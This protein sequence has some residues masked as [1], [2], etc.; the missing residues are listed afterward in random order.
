MAT[1]HFDFTSLGGIGADDHGENDSHSSFS[2]G[3]EIARLDGPRNELSRLL[4]ENDWEDALTM[5]LE[6]C[7]ASTNNNTG[8]DSIIHLA[9]IAETRNGKYEDR[10]GMLPLHYACR[11]GAP[12]NLIR[13]LLKAHPEGALAR[14]KES[15]RIALHFVAGG[16]D[17]GCGKRLHHGQ[18]QQ[19]PCREETNNR[20]A[21]ARILLSAFPQSIEMKDH[22][23]GMS[24]LHLACLV[25]AEPDLLAVLVDADQSDGVVS[26]PDDG[27]NLPLH[28]MFHPRISTDSVRRL[29]HAYPNGA[30]A[31]DSNGALPLHKACAVGAPVDAIRLLLSQYPHGAWTA[32]G[33]GNL[34]LHLIVP[35][36]PDGEVKQ[37]VRDA[38]I[39]ARADSLQE[40]LES[41]PEGARARNK[42][43]ETPFHR[44]LSEKASL[45]L[46]QLFLDA[47][48][49]C[50]KDIVSSS[51]T[52]KEGAANI[53]REKPSSED[54]AV[55]NIM[56]SLA[57]TSTTG[58]SPLH[59]ACRYNAPTDVIHALLDI[60]PQQARC[61]ALDGPGGAHLPIHAACRTGASI[62]TINALLESY[63]EG[64]SRPDGNDG[65]LPLHLEC[66]TRCNPGA[67]GMLLGA[68]G[69]G[70]EKVD[71]RGR[72]ALHYAAECY[73]T[74]DG[75]EVATILLEAFPGALEVRD[76][77]GCFPCLNSTSDEEDRLEKE[78]DAEAAV[79]AV[80]DRKKSVHF[81]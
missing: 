11:E 49:D 1:F 30:H 47:S 44:A 34:P 20:I 63:P 61:Y 68:C 9:Y 43:G 38:D 27:G 45:N 58:L 57:E 60:D 53:L 14:V 64:A 4:V 28:W 56:E 19:Q 52:G 70:A 32:D 16:R 13:D 33:S 76:N 36:F 40:L 77:S 79:F 2:S 55:S 41:Y 21:A 31:V 46:A 3:S 8:D 65:R 29:L 67:V 6:D 54:G 35:K 78:G 39:A 59:L 7:H 15:G 75:E 80:D 50:C 51:S 25:E 74:S 23:G 24:P 37:R 81:A 22:D 62:D 66:M 12:P 26:M 18:H 17:E 73:G 48:P 69:A 72:T 71:A 42:Y 10:R 5:I